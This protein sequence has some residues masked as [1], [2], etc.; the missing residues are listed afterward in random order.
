MEYNHESKLIIFNTYHSNTHHCVVRACLVSKIIMYIMYILPMFLY[1]RRNFKGNRSNLL[2]M[3]TAL[4]RRVQVMLI[5]VRK[6]QVGHDT[7]PAYDE[8]FYLQMLKQW[9][10]PSTYKCLNHI[11]DLSKRCKKSNVP[12][13]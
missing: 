12:L 7:C 9:K 2:P 4:L 8:S 5:R 6:I 13:K 10:F 1:A 11:S 3:C